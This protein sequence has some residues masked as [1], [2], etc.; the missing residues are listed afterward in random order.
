MIRKEDKRKKYNTESVSLTIRVSQND[1]KKVKELAESQGKSLSMYGGEII[2]ESLKTYPSLKEIRKIT[3][4][5]K[6]AFEIV[7]KTEQD[8]EK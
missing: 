1:Y 8:E 7:K 3:K 4:A 2:S 6:Y 5:L